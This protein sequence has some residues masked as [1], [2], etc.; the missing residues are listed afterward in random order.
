MLRMRAVGLQAS[1]SLIIG[2]AALMVGHMLIAMAR[3]AYGI[4][5]RASR[6]SLDSNGGVTGQERSGIGAATNSRRAALASHR[7]RR[8]DFDTRALSVAMPVLAYIW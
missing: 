6:T 7:A 4:T 2:V 8:A 3:H 5:R 1:D